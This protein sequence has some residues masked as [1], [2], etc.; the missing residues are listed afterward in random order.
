MCT[1]RGGAATAKGT[2][3][4]APKNLGGI[5]SANAKVLFLPTTIP[6]VSMARAMF[7]LSRGGVHWQG[8]PCFFFRRGGSIDTRTGGPLTRVLVK[9]PKKFFVYA[10]S[11]TQLT[12]NS[13]GFLVTVTVTVST[14]RQYTPSREAITANKCLSVCLSVYL[15]FFVVPVLCCVCVCICVF[16]TATIKTPEN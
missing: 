4:L 7:L 14:K 3:K 5:P 16:R 13:H 12:V 10:F 2:E 8:G 6:P 1:P 9:N 15:S 11:S